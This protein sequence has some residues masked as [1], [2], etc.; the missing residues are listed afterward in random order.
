MDD[1]AKFVC[2]RETLSTRTATCINDYIKLRFRQK[3][4]DVQS[5]D[6]AA[7]AKFFQPSVEQVSWIVGIHRP[8][9]F[10]A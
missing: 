7:G 6:V 3:V 1:C 5:M 9:I 8:L 10:A 2:Q 4:Q